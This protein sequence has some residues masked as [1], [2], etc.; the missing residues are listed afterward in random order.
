MVGQLPVVLEFVATADRVAGRLAESQAV[1][2]EGLELARE[3]GYT[4]TVAAHLANLAVLAALRGE[5]DE[6]RRLAQEALAIALPTGWG[7]ARVWPRTRWPCWTWGRAGSPRPTTGS[8]RSRRPG[9]AP[10]IRRSCGVRRRTGSRP[11]SGWAT[12][13]RPGRRWRRTSGG[14]R[15]RP[16][17]SPGPAGPVPGPGHGWPRGLRGGA[18]AARQ[19]VRGGQDRAAA[20]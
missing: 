16:R 6:C 19:P 8:R 15:T 9:R 14:R 4:N 3:A 13:R 17:P 1:S 18:A 5:E 11:P 12:W 20:G 7:C 10:G 2:E